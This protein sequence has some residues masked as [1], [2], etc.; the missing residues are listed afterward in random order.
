MTDYRDPS[1]AWVLKVVVIAMLVASAIPTSVFLYLDNKASD[2]QF[3]QN[4]NLISKVEAERVGVQERVND[5]IYQQCLQAEARDTIYA[6]WGSDLLLLLR[7]LPP[8]GRTDRNVQKLISDLEDG[9]E[10][11]EPDDE[12]D[13][14][15]PPATNP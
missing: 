3:S 13:C 8:Q 2:Q 1:I 12:A 6:Q 4:R 11:L 15:P 14:V 5:F 7:A 9:I 10:I